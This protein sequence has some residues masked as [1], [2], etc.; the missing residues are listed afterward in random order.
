LVAKYGVHG[1]T[2]SRIA[3]AVGLSRAALYK[4]FPSRD[5]VLAATMDLMDERSPNWIVQSSGDDV[6]LR[7]VN[8]GDSHA[9][10]AASKFETY[11]RPLFQFAAASEQGLLTNI[12]RERHLLF[13]QAAADLVEEG[14]REGSIRED[15]DSQDII[16]GLQMFAWAEDVA[17]LVG[18]DEMITSGASVRAF[19]RIL[20]D[21]SAASSTD[22]AG[23]S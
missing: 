15:A 17:R 3:A 22:C 13:L 7:L 14:K 2:V 10:W 23:N 19:R 20:G 18:L 1:A 4:H 6:F 12:M 21:I 5:A 8:M 11:I 16:W 9:S